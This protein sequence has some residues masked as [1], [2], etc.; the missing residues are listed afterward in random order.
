MHKMKIYEKFE[1]KDLLKKMIYDR[2]VN[3][4][5]KSNIIILLNLNI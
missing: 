2:L 3:F 4:D 5:K 1:K